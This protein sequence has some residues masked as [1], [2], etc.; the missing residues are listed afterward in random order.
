MKRQSK[1]FGVLFLLFAFGLFGLQMGVFL[2]QSTIH[3]EYIDYR[4]FY[5]INLGIAISLAVSFYFLLSLTKM[6]KGIIASLLAIF[7]IGNIGFMISSYSEIHNMKSTSPNKD[8]VV[9]IKQNIATNEAVYYR[10]YYKIFGRPME[11]LEHVADKP[12][13][14]EWLTND[15][16]AITYET[17][18]DHIQQFIATFGFRTTTSYYYVGA[19]IQ[20]AWFGEGVE[21]VSDQDGI[22]ITHN[23]TTELF[24]WEQIEQFGT[25][26][27]VLKENNEAKWTIALG[28]DFEMYAD[29][30]IPNSGEIILYKATIDNNQPLS[31]VKQEMN[32]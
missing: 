14:F 22:S 30:S 15:V 32:D 10:P 8:N 29:A 5:I 4:L 18:N 6:Q 2:I 19:E 3:I 27:V 9:S 17:A 7:I 25:L 12:M 31:L 26:A 16:A 24:D 28:E 23:Q 20:G 21:V 1:L 13:Q 11:R